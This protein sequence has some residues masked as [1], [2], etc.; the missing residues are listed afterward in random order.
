M[1]I[2]ILLSFTNKIEGAYKTV[3]RSVLSEFEISKTSFDILMFLS[4]NPDFCTAKEISD[5]RNI[6]ASV[7]SLHVDKMVREGYLVRQSVEEDRRKI[8]L[9]CTD[10]AQPIIE[11][12]HAVQREFF[13]SLMDGL[14]EQDRENFRHYFEVVAENADLIQSRK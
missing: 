3:C 12:G 7:V 8:R 10:K 14:T 4:N 5:K 13:F 9:V 2:S 11:K 1:N 6:K